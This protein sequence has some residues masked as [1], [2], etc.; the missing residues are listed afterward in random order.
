M[1]KFMTKLVTIEDLQNFV[2]E[3]RNA[4]GQVTVERGTYIVPASSIM[5]LVGL[6]LSKPII[7]AAENDED[8]EVF[9]CEKQSIEYSE[10]KEPMLKLI[11]TTLDKYASQIAQHDHMLL[12]DA[13]KEL[14]KR[15]EDTELA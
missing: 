8:I 6:D 11:K 2:V 7:V 4:K 5:A 12:C 3:A 9:S 1:A 14:E 10:P 13:I 15:M